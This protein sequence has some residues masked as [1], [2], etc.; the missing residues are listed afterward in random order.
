MDV[1]LSEN[2]DNKLA[3][4]SCMILIFQVCGH[5]ASLGKAGRHTQKKK[6]RGCH[7]YGGRSPTAAI[8]C[9]KTIAPPS[10]FHPSEVPGP[11]HTSSSV[12]CCPVCHAILDKP[13]ELMCGNVVCADCCCTWI[14]ISGKL[15][16]P[17]CYSLQAIDEHTKA[18]SPAFLDLLKSVR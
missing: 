1:Q 8:N 14:E 17:C 9:I 4:F 11:S 15:S 12:G 13:L 3:C 2:Y 16:C 7:M 18:P 5:L 6:G 10:T